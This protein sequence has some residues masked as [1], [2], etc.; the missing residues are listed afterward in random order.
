MGG[1]GGG[2]GGVSDLGGV[3][4]Y[5]CS[6]VMDANYFAGAA[7]VSAW[8]VCCVMLVVPA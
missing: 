6:T 8:L 2:W 1:L 3:G 5:G 4:V 7:Y